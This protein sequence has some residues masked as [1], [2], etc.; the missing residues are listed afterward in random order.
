MSNFP[1]SNINR[2]YVNLTSSSYPHMGS[3]ETSKQF[4]LPLPAHKGGRRSR[5][6]RKVRKGKK[7]RKGRR[8]TRQYGGYYQYG[9]NIGHTTSYSTAGNILDYSNSMLAN[10]TPFHKL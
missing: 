10:P 8:K 5:K 6:T 4:G 1:W 3:N 2:N 9:S 7:G